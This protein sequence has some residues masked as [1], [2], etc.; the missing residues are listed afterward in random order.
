MVTISHEVEFEFDAG[1]YWEE[2]LDD[3]SVDEI[4]EYLEK[5][6]KTSYAKRHIDEA[7]FEWHDYYHEDN[8]I[9]IQYYP[10]YDS[11]SAF[12]DEDS[13]LCEIKY[14]HELQHILWALGEDANLTI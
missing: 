13:E 4:E 12:Y 8:C 1:E 6:R 10:K 7:N 11:F 14:V 5:R 2:I 3:M 9:N